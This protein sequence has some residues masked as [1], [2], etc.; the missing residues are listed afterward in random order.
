MSVFPAKIALTPMLRRYVS[1]L[2]LLLIAT[3]A[4]AAEK[5]HKPALGSRIEKLLAEQDVARGFWGIEAVSLKTGKTLYARNSDHLFTPASNTKLFTTAATM[6]LVGPDYRLHTTVE[7]AG[8]IDKYGRLNSD[9]VL[10]GRGDPNLSGRVL[11][12]NSNADRR[13]PPMKV[14]EDLADQLVAKGLKFVDGDI[15]GDDSYYAF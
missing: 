11:P 8:A 6:G 9:L 14:L 2:L 1:A 15:V 10:V 12:Y 4:F 7:T 3:A 13:L 5:P